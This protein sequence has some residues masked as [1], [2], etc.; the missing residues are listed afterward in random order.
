MESKGTVLSEGEKTKS[1]KTRSYSKDTSGNRLDSMG[2]GGGTVTGRYAC[3]RI[4]K[5]SQLQSDI[6]KGVG[7]LVHN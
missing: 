4:T 2:G 7:S 6:L 1:I 5:C 3:D